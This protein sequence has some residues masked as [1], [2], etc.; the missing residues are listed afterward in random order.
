MEIRAA[1]RAAH[2]NSDRLAVL[3]EQWASCQGIWKESHIYLQLS[4]RTRHRKVGRRSWLT[5]PE[6]VKKYGDQDAATLIWDNKI[7]EDDGS[8]SQVRPHPDCPSVLVTCTHACMHKNL[9]HIMYVNYRV[10]G[11][12]NIHRSILHVACIDVHRNYLMSCITKGL[13]EL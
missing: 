2:R 8:G 13:P 9:L 11:D 10:H 6:L 4:Q 1:G 3:F 5:K 12:D 7:A